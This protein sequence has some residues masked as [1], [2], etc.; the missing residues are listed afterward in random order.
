M[1]INSG[2]DR[3]TLDDWFANLEIGLVAGHGVWLKPKGE[4]W[5]LIKPLENGWKPNLLPLLEVY[6]DRLPGSF[7]EEKEFSL[8]WH[9]RACQPELA[10]VRA[11]ELVDYLVDFSSSRDLQVLHGNKVV[12]IRCAG[13]N[14]GTAALFWLSK[15]EYDFVLAVGDDWT[16]EDLFRVLPEKAYSIRVG[17][18]HT[19]TRFNLYNYRDVVELLIYLGEIY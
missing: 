13:V 16:D 7:I 1:I 4:D 12:E 15:G 19:Y 18:G 6:V 17:I 14:K 2:R 5:K 9:Y 11:K 10:S 8:A 3:K